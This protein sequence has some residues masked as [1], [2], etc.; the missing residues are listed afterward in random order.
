MP[1]SGDLMLTRR[2]EVESDKGTRPPTR[3]IGGFSIV[4]TVEIG[5]KV[6][7]LGYFARKKVE[8]R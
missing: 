8:R 1:C 3:P 7:R 4:R 6:K 5:G 2:Y